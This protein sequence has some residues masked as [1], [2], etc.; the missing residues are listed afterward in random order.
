MEKSR[1]L[2]HVLKLTVFFNDIA[3]L[4]RVRDFCM[5]DNVI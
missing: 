2:A 3:L 4:D 5:R 1:D